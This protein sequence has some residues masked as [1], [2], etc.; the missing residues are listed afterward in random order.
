MKLEALIQ[1]MTDQIKE[2]Q[3]KLGYARET[4]RLYY[5]LSSLNAMLETQEK[6]IRELAKKIRRELE[7]KIQKAEEVSAAP[8]DSQRE[9]TS[10]EP[11]SMKPAKA[12]EDGKM[13]GSIQKTPEQAAGFAGLGDIQIRIHADRIVFTIPPD[14]VEYV[15]QHVPDPPFLKELIQLFQE[16]HACTKEEITAV[17]GKFGAYECRQMP[18]GMDF[19]YVIYFTN[20]RIDAYDYCIR[21]EMGHT[22]YHRFARAD[23]EGL[24]EM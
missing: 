16:K 11:E 15:H 21:E 20:G 2:A 10:V 1:N 8:D 5:P 17:F 4:M 19:D 14:F 9:L 23:F 7:E 6:D 22:I 24:M 3:L 12:V 18:D 13:A